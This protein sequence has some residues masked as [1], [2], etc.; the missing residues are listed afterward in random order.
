MSFQHLYHLTFGDKSVRVFRSSHLELPQ[1]FK[2]PLSDWFGPKYKCKISSYMDNTIVLLRS[3]LNLGFNLNYRFFCT[4]S[5]FKIFFFTLHIFFKNQTYTITSLTFQVSKMDLTTF[6][7]QLVS[8][9][10]VRL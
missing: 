6:L 9:L 8:V 7:A 3:K 1:T 5:A 2:R 10:R 4:F